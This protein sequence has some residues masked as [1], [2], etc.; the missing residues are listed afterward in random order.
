M[1]ELELADELGA[2][3]GDGHLLRDPELRTP[4]EHDLTGR[5]H[6]EAALVV[7]PANTPEVA[8][9]IRACARHRVAVVPQGGHTGLVG[10]GTPRNGEVVL[11]LG[12]LAEVSPAGK[13]LQQLE[14]GSGT[15]LAAVHGQAAAAG[16][17]FPVDLD[18]RDSATCG[19]LAATDAGGARALSYGTMRAHVDGLEA[20]LADGS[21]ISRLPA[22]AKDNAGY[23]LTALLVGSEGTLGVITRLLLRLS[24]MLEHRVTALFAMPD[25]GAAVRLVQRARKRLFSLEA[26]DFFCD[27]GLR[28]SLEQQQMNFPLKERGEVYVLL[29][30]AD[31][32]DPTTA[33]AEALADSD[34][35][36]DVA[37]ASD[38]H[39]R[40]ELWAARVR[41]H[42]TAAALGVPVKLDVAVPPM[43]IPAFAERVRDIVSRIDPRANIILFGHLG[44]GNVHVNICGL[45]SDS[46]KVERLV[47]TLAAR[48]GG[49]ISAE[50]GIG[51]A[52]AQYLALVRSRAEIEAMRALKRAL[53]PQAILNPGVVL[54]MPL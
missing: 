20:V 33:L 25:M 36:I 4:Y 18:A 13:A 3:V 19:G 6:G 48:S 51:I 23:D 52:K 27:V 38:A 37:V 11:N 8:A 31:R 5:F 7:R 42:E 54:S 44:D 41:Q 10:G 47:L 49:T 15:T 9:V 17:S 12:R 53:D 35:V 32:H 2:I 46:D 1:S 45:S 26:A 39:G 50:H 34:E 24:P 40:Q 22:V 21:V 30:C 16:M 43:R 14:V 28:F 29:E